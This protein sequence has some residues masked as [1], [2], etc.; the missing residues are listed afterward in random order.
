MENSFKKVVE[1]NV[2]NSTK[3]MSN[4]E[5]ILTIVCSFFFLIYDFSYVLE[6][7]KIEREE[8]WWTV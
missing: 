7:I 8:N 3:L 4:R 1:K 6:Y 2:E 5:I